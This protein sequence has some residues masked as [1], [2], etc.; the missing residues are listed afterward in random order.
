[1]ASIHTALAVVFIVIMSAVLWTFRK[2]VTVQKLLGPFLYFVMLR[3]TWGIGLMDWFGSRFRKL[4]QWFGYASIVIGFLGMALIT[5]QLVKSTLMLFLTP[6]AAPGIQPVLP[7]E[8]KGVFFVPFAF[9]IISIFVIAVIH[10]FSHG[11]LARS[12]NITVKSSGFAFL[13][14]LVPVIPAAFVEPDEKQ[15]VK[16]P[17]SQQLSVFAAGPVANI[18]MAIAMVFLFGIDASPLI[19]YDITSRTA[20]VDVTELGTSLITF[21]HFEVNKIEPDSPASR[22]GLAIGDR[23]TAVDGI[24]VMERDRTLERITSLKPNEAV[25]L[26]IGDRDVQVLLGEHPEDAS[27]GY[28]GIGFS[29]ATEYAADA[30]AKYG[31]LGVQTLLFFISLVIWVFILSI[32][33][34]L[35]NLIPLGPIDGGRMLKLALE[36]LT[37]E[38]SGVRIWKG[39]SMA[40][41]GMVI[42]NLI[43]GFVR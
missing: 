11:V 12:H 18:V 16:R 41:L 33:I 8:A 1:M 5:Y 2:Q 9:W 22:A 3:T 10:E 28:L 13:A 4:M 39:V 40:I 14:A 36:R 7:F 24:S 6:E 20:I 43:V 37:S 27:R 15:L 21:S 34:G 35:F 26:S 19:P 29:T 38:A 17:A 30:L 25:T 23:I 42:V 31:E 32:G